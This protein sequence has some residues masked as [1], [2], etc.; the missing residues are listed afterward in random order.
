MDAGLYERVEPLAA[1]LAGFLVR[2]ARIVEALRLLREMV[3]AAQRRGDLVREA[4][5]FLAM[6][7]QYAALD[8]DER[9]WV[10]LRV[11]DR[12]Q[13]RRGGDRHLRP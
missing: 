9:S 1:P 12:F 3:I 2:Q 8:D 7:R 11:Y 5:L 13:T 4:D 10:C 6:G